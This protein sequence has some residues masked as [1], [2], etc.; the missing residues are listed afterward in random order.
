MFMSVFV[1]IRTDEGRGLRNLAFVASEDR[2]LESE[3]NIIVRSIDT[4]MGR[5]D[6]AHEAKK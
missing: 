5:F 6:N 3:T 4:L 1:V 2:A